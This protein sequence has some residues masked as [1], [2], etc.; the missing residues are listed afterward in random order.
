MFDEMKSEIQAASKAFLVENAIEVSYEPGQ[1]VIHSR[2]SEDVILAHANYGPNAFSLYL[3]LIQ[4]CKEIILIYYQDVA[5]AKEIHD[6]LEEYILELNPE[7]I[8]TKEKYS[9]PIGKS[10]SSY[11]YCKRMLLYIFYRGICKF[12]LCSSIGD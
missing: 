6:A 3:P 10:I 9:D 8:L 4:S 1:C 7:I 5:L 12:G 2:L 11:L